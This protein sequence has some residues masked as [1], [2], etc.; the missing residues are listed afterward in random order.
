MKLKRVEDHKVCVKTTFTGSLE[1]PFFLTS[2]LKTKKMRHLL[3]T[4]VHPEMQECFFLRGIE[5]RPP[6]ISRTDRL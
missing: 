6:R 5:Y 1:L 2:A 3:F 4:A